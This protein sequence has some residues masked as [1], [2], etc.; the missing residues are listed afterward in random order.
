M[1]KLLIIV[2]VLV[3]LFSLAACQ[4]TENSGQDSG[5]GDV[6]S[7]SEYP[8]KVDY[9]YIRSQN[10]STGH[11][12]SKTIDA[13]LSDWTDEEKENCIS[14]PVE[15]G[16]N[17]TVYAVKKTDGIYIAYDILHS[18]IMKSSRDPLI[19][20]NV[21]F[22][23][24]DGVFRYVSIDDICSGVTDY[25][26]VSEKKEGEKR[27]TVFEIFVSKEEVEG[28][29]ED[30]YG[31]FSFK[32][33]EVID[34]YWGFGSTWN[35]Y[36]NSNNNASLMITEQGL[37]RPGEA[38]AE[39][40]VF[41]GDPSEDFWEDIG[42]EGNITTSYN[43]DG[44]FAMQAVLKEDGVYIAFTAEHNDNANYPRYW[45]YNTNFEIKIGSAQAYSHHIIAMY[46]QT[47]TL[48]TVSVKEAK[49]ITVFDDEIEKYVTLAEIFIPYESCI[50]GASME[51][52]D[53][54]IG[55]SFRADAA[56][57]QAV[58]AMVWT[59]LYFNGK[60]TWE[61]NAL[62]VTAQGLAA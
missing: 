9:S 42:G 31:G 17:M 13:D 62:R 59:P 40:V 10:G 29:S 8:E 51:S 27:H 41:D 7:G 4:G 34:Y 54:Y 14:L 44:Y 11:A 45:C 61:M 2:L 50:E 58:G 57:S 20:T 38:P 6:V 1:K 18:I 37:L 48:S 3:C 46:E 23:L 47:Q 43:Y 56:S 35:W 22:S 12:Q 24:N 60:D 55:A 39:G 21:S 32:D 30:I 28:F 19:N 49:M 53:L 36:D 52:E 15:G 16:Q 33:Q 5:G 25:S 26:F